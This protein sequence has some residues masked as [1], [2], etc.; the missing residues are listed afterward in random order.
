MRLFLGVVFLLLATASAS[1]ER[2]RL[3]TRTPPKPVPKVE[4]LLTGHT[5]YLNRCVGGCSI[6]PGEDDATAGD[7][8]AAD[9]IVSGIPSRAT[10]LPEYDEFMPGEWEATVQCVKEVYSPFAVNIT[11]VRPTNGSTFQT[12]LVGGTRDMPGGVAVGAPG[13]GGVAFSGCNPL[14]KGVSYAFTDMLDIFAQEIGGSRPLA[15]CWIIA[16][17][18]AHNLGLEHEFDFVEDMRSACNDPMTYRDDCGGQKFF[19]NKFARCGEFPG[20]GMSPRN[21]ACNPTQ[22]SHLKLLNTFGPGTSLIAAPTVAVTTPAQSSMNANSLPANIVASA[23]SKRGVNRVELFLN[24][25]KWVEVN[26]AQFGRTGQL[27]PSS[28]GLL[29]PAQSIPDSIYDIEVRAYDDLE[30]VGTSQVVTAV[31]GAAGGCVSA[32]SCLEGQLCQQGRCFWEPPVGEIGDAC[33]YPQFCKNEI[34]QGTAETQICTQTC[35]VGNADSC[36]AE[37]GLTCVPSGPN[38]QTGICFFPEEG[39]CCSAS[40]GD[41]PWGPFGLAGLVLGFIVFRRRR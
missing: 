4:K 32:D 39:G 27:N 12:I 9:P 11:D 5:I 6:I 15:L 26:G 29:V 24:G 25:Y 30:L 2:P 20:D 7:G 36:P 28:Y 21:C 41:A 38:S 31:K 14:V 33:T 37:S 13:S 8:T 35:V 16:Q 40:N 1:A 22:N 19:R 17:E 34:C 23:G 18:T 3:E 10:V